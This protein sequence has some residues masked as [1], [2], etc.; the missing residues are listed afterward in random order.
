MAKFTE[1]KTAPG[2]MRALALLGVVAGSISVVG[3]V[4]VSEYAE[5]FTMLPGPI[6]AGMFLA[7]TGRG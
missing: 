2:G 4:M 3:N 1:C 5:A 7:Y 6:W